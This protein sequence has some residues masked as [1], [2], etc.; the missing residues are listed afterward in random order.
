MKTWLYHPEK[1][2]KVF[3]SDV[4]DMQALDETGWK[5]TPAA[6]EDIASDTGQADPDQPA[7]NIKSRKK[8]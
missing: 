2:A 3:D 6:F 8:A 5:D 1:G 4:D 7:E